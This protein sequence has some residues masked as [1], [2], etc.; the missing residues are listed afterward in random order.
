MMTR[1]VAHQKMFQAALDAI[2]DNFPSGALEGD[3]ELGHAYVADSGNFGGGRGGGETCACRES[4]LWL[5]PEGL[6]FGP[7]A[8]MIIAHVPAVRVCPDHAGRRVAAAAAA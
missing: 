8:V 5:W 4:R 7:S 3:P 1:E 6:L 2:T